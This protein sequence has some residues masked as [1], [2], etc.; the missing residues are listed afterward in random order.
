MIT[1]IQT[2]ATQF[3]HKTLPKEAWTHHAHIAVAFAQVHQFNNEE[4]TLQSLQQ[5]IKAYNLSVGTQNTENSGYHETLTVFWLKAVYEYYCISKQDDVND[6]F[7]GFIHSLLASPT[8]P[9]QFFSKE[10]LFSTSARQTWTEPDLLPI[11][12]LKEMVAA[13]M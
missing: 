6:M 9:L 4:K 8:L 11:S 7:Q 1:D 2:I 13:T 12:T 5:G 10:L 3:E